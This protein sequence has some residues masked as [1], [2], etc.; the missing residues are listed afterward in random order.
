MRALSSLRSWLSPPA[1]PAEDEAALDRHLDDLVRF[2]GQGC[3]LVLNLLH[4][5]FWPTDPW[6]LPDPRVLAVMHWFR[7]STFSVHALFLLALRLPSLHR[8]PLPLFAAGVA[9]SSALFGGAMAALGGL[10][11][12]YFYMTYLAPMGVGAMPA[13]PARRLWLSPACGAVICLAYFLA[14]PEHAASPHLGAALGCMAFTVVISFAIGHA[15]YLLTRRAF[16]TGLALDR[17]R[18]IL[19]EYSE[20]L[21]DKVAEHALQLR[22]LAAYREQA[23]TDER[24]RLARELHDEVGQQIASLRY[25]VAALARHGHGAPAVGELDQGLTALG[26]AVRTLVADLRPRV[27]DEQGLGPAVRWLFDRA[28]ARTGLPCTVTIREAPGLTIPAAHAGAAFRI[29][30]EA[31]TNALRHAGPRTIHAELRIDGDGIHAS[32]SDDGRGIGPVDMIRAGMGLFG[33]SERAAAL[34]GH[35]EIAGRPGQGTVV[36]L[37]LPLHDEPSSATAVPHR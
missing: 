27:L 14:R 23:A 5:V 15:M 34:G 29:V 26:E 28:A 30:Q 35:V 3:A 12:P 16:L 17:S 11:Q 8:R 10:D 9:V 33:M 2:Y 19:E 21:E 20:H 18:D 36:R 22:R 31:L 6:L 32:V 1:A 24:A 7:A 13:R 37:H 25:T 4:L